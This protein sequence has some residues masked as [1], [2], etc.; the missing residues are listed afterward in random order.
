MIDKVVF[1]KAGHPSRGKTDSDFDILIV[2]ADTWDEL[3]QVVDDAL[4]NFW[5]AWLISNNHETNKPSAVMYQPSGATGPW[6]D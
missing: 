5:A 6:S 1:Y 2:T 3:D 4:E